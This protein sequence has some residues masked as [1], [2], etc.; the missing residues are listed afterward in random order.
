MIRAVNLKT[1]Y[2]INPIGIDIQKPHL[3]WNVEGA[4]KQ[5]AYSI[6]AKV[7][8]ETIWQSGKISSSS[9]RAEYGGRSLLSRERVEWAVTLWDENNEPG[10]ESTAF[11]EVGLL[12]PSDWSAKWITADCEIN[13]KLRYPVDHFKKT[14]V[15]DKPVKRARLYITACGLY[16]AELNG[17]KVGNAELT[18]G[19][20]DYRKRVQYQTFD[21]TGLLREGE[22]ALEVALADGWYRGHLGALSTRNV[23]GTR[24]K[25]LCQLEIEYA[26]GT[27]QTIGSDDSFTWS[28]DGDIRYADLKNGEVVEAGRCPS[29]AGRARLDAHP[30]RLSASNNVPV[31][32]H[33]RFTPKLILSPVGSKILDFG[34]NIAGFM[35]FRVKGEKGQK[36]TLK[37]GEALDHGEFTQV[38]FQG[39][40]KNID[41]KIEFT[42]SGGEDLYRTKFAIFGFR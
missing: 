36:I 4:K 3:F 38:N 7:D 10:Q 18:P 24:T 1:E 39:K 22:N 30:V 23:F 12:Q 20:T 11:F 21:V 42:C 37:M 31:Q 27:H 41:Q 16:E 8:E 25:M 17:A 40:M 14:F 13:K 32:Q 35:E 33:E 28:N 2:L 5:T 34:Q 26:D 29:Y 9:M 19:L 6:T 15:A